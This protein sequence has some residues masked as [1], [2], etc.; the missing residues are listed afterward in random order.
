MS[1]AKKVR[2]T[3]T[4][5]L[6]GAEGTPGDVVTVDADLAERWEAVGGCVVLDDEDAK[7]AAKPVAKPAAKPKE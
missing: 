1:A 2:L 3:H 4:S 7:P 6:K 5:N